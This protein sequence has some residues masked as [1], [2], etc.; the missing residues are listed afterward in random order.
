MAESLAAPISNTALRGAAVVLSAST[1]TTP[2]TPT[3]NERWW[4]WMPIACTLFLIM[5]VFAGCI[6]IAWRLSRS[7]AHEVI[8]SRSTWTG[9]IC[10]HRHGCIKYTL[11]SSGVV[12]LAAGLF[13]LIMAAL[14][15][16]EH[17]GQV[18]AGQVDK[19]FIVLPALTYL[20]LAV[21]FGFSSAGLR[22]KHDQNGQQV[23]LAFRQNS[24]LS[25]LAGM[26]SGI[27][28]EVLCGVDNKYFN[29]PEGWTESCQ[30]LGGSCALLLLGMIVAQADG[31]E[32]RDFEPPP[33]EKTKAP[34][35]EVLHRQESG[36]ASLLGKGDSLFDRLGPKEA[37]QMESPTEKKFWV[38][39]HPI[40]EEERLGSRKTRRGLD[41]TSPNSAACRGL[42]EPLLGAAP[43]WHEPETGY[44]TPVSR[45]E[46]PL[47]FPREIDE[48][49]SP[50]EQLLPGAYAPEAPLLS[51]GSSLSGAWSSA[52][53][54]TPPSSSILTSPPMRPTVLAV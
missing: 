53:G 31:A 6:R 26:A 9:W 19:W 54:F 51:D 11:R 46:D 49:C 33:P 4:L 5:A 41:D 18:L 8:D 17:R 23:Y 28:Q 14:R 3:K 7:N 22:W 13:G 24:Q 21:A 10:S 1:T 12:G 32:K 35:Q 42:R 20:F 47:D 38:P 52:C 36:N 34:P 37:S 44:Q 50:H 48:S 39:E 16:Y 29:V 27:S 2:D 30:M 40:S 43:P 45:L 25:F 15:F